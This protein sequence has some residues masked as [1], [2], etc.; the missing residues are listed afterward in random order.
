M[1]NVVEGNPVVQ[2][3]A[4]SPQNRADALRVMRDGPEL[5]ILVVAGGVVVVVVVA[6]PLG[7]IQAKPAELADRPELS[8][9]ARGTA[10]H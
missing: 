6:V 2:P 10:A 3:V 5:D 8:L 7:T 1:D 9:A 4:L